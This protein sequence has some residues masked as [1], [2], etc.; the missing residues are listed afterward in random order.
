[1]ICDLLTAYC[2][3]GFFRSL[4]RRPETVEARRDVQQ[5]VRLLTVRAISNLTGCCTLSEEDEMIH[6]LNVRSSKRED[7]VDITSRV[8][9]LIRRESK[10]EGICYLFVQHTTAGITI[11][12][13]ADPNVGRDMLYALARLI[14]KDDPNYRHNE[15]N[16]D[17][18]IKSSL[19]GHSAYVPFQDGRLLL[20][21]WQGIF[22]CEF[23]GPR[24]RTVKVCLF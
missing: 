22:L 16:S 12:E 13:N 6:T 14:P 3:W 10:S 8:A 7:L 11:N 15:D 19:T 9:E 18:H 4:V 5:P 24:E 21:R 2:F 1:V 20:G 17:A 23:D